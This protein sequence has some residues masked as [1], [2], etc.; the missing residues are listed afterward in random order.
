MQAVFAKILNM[1]LT[2]SIV[3]AVVLLA[4]LFLKRAP[5]IYSY[6]LWAVV[7][8]RLLCP[9]SITAGLSVLKPIPVTTTPGIST[10]SY[11]SVARA[12]RENTPA[13]I[14]QQ[15][16]PAQTAQTDTK[17][18][19]MQIAAYIWL[20]GASVMAVYSIAQF[21]ALRHRLAESVPVQ[22]NVYLADRISTPFVM[23]VIRPRVYLPSGTPREAETYILAHEEHHIRRGDPVWKLL[24]YAALCLHWFNPLVWLAFCLAGKDME[25]SCDEAVIKQLGEIGRASC[26]ERV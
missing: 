16:V 4:R 3:I 23:G 12:V 15:V 22:E 25:M 14:Q 5:K 11:Q 6:A 26:R 10:V 21:F 2:G 7:L 19:P 9:L 18:S 13:P 20:A 1:S 8:F 17:P 24:G